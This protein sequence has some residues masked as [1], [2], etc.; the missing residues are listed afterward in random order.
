[1]VFRPVRTASIDKNG[2]VPSSNLHKKEEK[3]FFLKK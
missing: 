3:E 2:N 1:M